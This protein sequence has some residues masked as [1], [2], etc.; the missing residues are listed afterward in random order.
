MKRAR[1]RVNIKETSEGFFIKKIRTKDLDVYDMEDFF[2]D[3]ITAIEVILF[4]VGFIAFWYWIFFGP[5]Y[6][7]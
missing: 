3:L 2:C 5:S 1:I 4:V 6:V 7:R